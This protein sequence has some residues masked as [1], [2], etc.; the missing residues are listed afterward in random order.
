MIDT[1]FSVHIEELERAEKS[2]DLLLNKNGDISN[3]K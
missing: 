2:W 1:L 3:E